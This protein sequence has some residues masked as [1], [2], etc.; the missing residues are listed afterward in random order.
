MINTIEGIFDKAIDGLDLMQ[1]ERRKYDPENALKIGQFIMKLRE[2]K[3]GETLPFTFEVTDPSGNS[4]I[5]NPNAPEA[6]PTLKVV[7][8]DR[9]M[10]DYTSMGYN[11]EE[12]AA[13]MA[14]FSDDQPIEKAAAEN[15]KDGKVGESSRAVKQTA[16]E[17][18]AMLMKLAAYKK[19]DG[20]VVRKGIDFSDGATFD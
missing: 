16:E 4:F 6:D 20:K 1:A 7:H 11:A 2:Y 12:A 9:S 14:K 15:T 18:D 10:E 5:Q 17:Q 19:S 3:N 13:S 8:F